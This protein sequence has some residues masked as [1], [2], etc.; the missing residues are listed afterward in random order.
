MTSSV[1]YRLELCPTELKDGKIPADYPYKDIKHCPNDNAG[2]DLAILKDYELN[3][4]IIKPRLLPFGTKARL[5]RINEETEDETDTHYWLVPRSSLYK[6]GLMMAN[7]VGVIDSSYRGELKAPIARLPGTG[8]IEL[9][10]GDRLFQI[11][12]PDM[13][14]IKEV[15]VVKGLPETA[16]GEKGFGSSGR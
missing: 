13:G 14:W 1:Y 15:R 4:E 16:R 8:L 12:A 3:E 11:V 5:V 7:S 10:A 2:F 6:R 9:T